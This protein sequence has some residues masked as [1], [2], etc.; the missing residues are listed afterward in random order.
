MHYT[1]RI[2]A[3]VF[4]FVAFATLVSA[5][6][7]AKTPEQQARAV[8]HQMF[9]YEPKTKETGVC[10][11]V[12]VEEGVALTAAH[13]KPGKGG[14]AIV[15][16]GEEKLKVTEWKLYPGTDL[17]RITVPGLK[18]DCVALA[19]GR[20]AID[21]PVIVVGYPYG[22]GKVLTRGEVQGRVQFE[23]EELLLATACIAGGNSGGGLFVVRDGVIYLVGITSRGSQEGCLSLFVE[24]GQ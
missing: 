6:T 5:Q 9:M 23:G 18:C 11:V 3:A 15:V 4:A 20:P 12:V 17:A 1:A 14:K 22:I 2:A 21:T 8:V 7:P 19:S 16:V 10:S 24:V 13:C